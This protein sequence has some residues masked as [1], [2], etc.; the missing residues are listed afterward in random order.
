MKPALPRF[1]GSSSG[2]DQPAALEPYHL[3]TFG[4]TPRNGFLLVPLLV[5]LVWLLQD[6]RYDEL[7]WVTWLAAGLLAAMGVTGLAYIVTP[8]ELRADSEGVR[9]TQFGY[10]KVLRWQDIESVGIGKTTAFEGHDRPSVRLMTGNDATLFGRDYIGVNLRQSHS[11]AGTVAYK[12]GITGFDLN[13]RNPFDVA[14]G[15]IVAELQVRWEA[16]QRELRPALSS[17]G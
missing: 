16:S 11:D 14:T 3:R 7:T 17:E 6:Y 1:E 13:F 8:V 2:V 5:G 4:L 12:R 9:W 10:R 15:V